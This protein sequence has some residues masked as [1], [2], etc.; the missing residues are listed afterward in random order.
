MSANNRIEGG[1][2]ENV[3]QG[4]NFTFLTLEAPQ[5]RL[6]DELPLRPPLVARREAE[7]G[8]V[9]D[10]LR[11]PGGGVVV[12]GPPGCGK[13]ALVTEAAHRAVERGWF[14]GGVLYADLG[15]HSGE[16]PADPAQLAGAFLRRL[17]VRGRH[18]PRDR[19][20]LAAMLRGRLRER[21]HSHGAVLLVLDD[22]A[23]AAQF[24][25]LLPGGP[26]T[27]LVTSRTRLTVD[28]LDAL[29]LGVFSAED[30]RTVLTALLPKIPANP[31]EL[32][33]LA[34]LCGHLALSLRVAAARTEEDGT[35][36][37]LLAAL[38]AENERLAELE[39]DEQFS[40]RAAFAASYRALSPA[41]ARLLRLLGLHP[42]REIGPD[43]AAALA[44]TTVA[45]TQRALRRLVNA[46]LLE[47][48]DER[49]R[50]R[51]HDLWRLYARERLAAEEPR[52]KREM[53][54][55]ALVEEWI[56]RAGQ[57]DRAWLDREQD[58]LLAALERDFAA[59]AHRRVARLGVP[60]AR[61]L[62]LRARPAEALTVLDRLV[63]VAQRQGN[64]LTEANLLLEMGAEYR[65]L[66]MA[67]AEEQCFHAAYVIC[68]QIG[69]LYQVPELA[70]WLGDRLRQDGD[71]REARWCRRQAD[72]AR[73][74]GDLAGRIQD[75]NRLALDHLAEGSLPRARERLEAARR[76]GK[77][78]SDRAARALTRAT[79]AEL[80]LAQGKPRQAL[81][82]LRRSLSHSRAA[83]DL[84]SLLDRLALAH[85]LEAAG[86]HPDRA[87]ARLA[88]GLE[89]CRAYQ[90]PAREREFTELLAAWHQGQGDH[91]QAETLRAAAGRIATEAGGP[92][93]PVPPRPSGPR[94]DAIT[95]TRYFLW[96]WALLLCSLTGLLATTLLPGL[97]PVSGSAALWGGLSAMGAGRV[98]GQYYTWSGGIRRPVWQL[99]VSMALQVPPAFAWAAWLL[100]GQHPVPPTVL[101]QL[102]WWGFMADGAL[103]MLP[104]VSG[105]YGTPRD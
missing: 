100:D 67:D 1:R 7:L 86:H 13:T 64:R 18:L 19:G 91:R 36:G 76:L 98:W 10:A 29:P 43:A 94:L 28:G 101:S 65:Q 88:E 97:V 71:F 83:G 74:P 38:R 62:A 39:V 69:A 104:Y 20:H 105:R 58:A 2:A 15:G 3:F 4:E 27:V 11:G 34:A 85:R 44:G 51:F 96:P 60:L 87:R 57:D 40:V 41:D 26:H 12:S 56:R 16:P 23:S 72:S 66:G 63:A 92:A 75:L 47:R 54:W 59:G 24:A 77:G 35:T 48:A 25:A 84:R 82:H 103:S 102:V 14:P 81:D 22:A 9:L 45:E 6:L 89:I 80:C 79:L 37:P 61:H 55:Q 17:A 46:H 90:L 93:V 70:H 31:A 42:G 32:D 30:S 33:E 73:A 50:V 5:P 78:C 95:V 99:K 49:G 52:R 8:R 53:A 21:A 68:D